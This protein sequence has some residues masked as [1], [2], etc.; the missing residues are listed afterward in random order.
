MASSEALKILQTARDLLSSMEA[1]RL[2]EACPKTV[3]ALQASE[4]AISDEFDAP[5]RAGKK[6]RFTVSTRDNR[7]LQFRL[8]YQKKQREKVADAIADSSGK[9]AHGLVT[10]LWKARIVLTS[11]TMPSRELREWFRTVS[12]DSLAVVGH[13][14]IERARDAFCEILRGLRKQQL[15]ATIEL[16][17]AEQLASA[18]RDHSRLCGY[19]SSIC[20][21][22]WACD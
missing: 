12:I 5:E 4:D 11:P 13:A 17:A 7:R 20:M 14:Y 8:A 3:Q 21:T 22:K 9:K 18:P 1:E 6:R 15:A 2:L 19:T 16:H 10:S